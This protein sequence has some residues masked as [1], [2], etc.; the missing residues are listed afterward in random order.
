MSMTKEEALTRIKELEQYVKDIDK[1]K[2]SHNLGAFYREPNN[3]E[4]YLLAQVDTARV[5]LISLASGNRWATPTKVERASRITPEEFL[6]ICRGAN[7][8]QVTGVS[9]KLEK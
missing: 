4:L 3:G 2:D 8:K 7:F 1:P 6:S 9:I 5:T